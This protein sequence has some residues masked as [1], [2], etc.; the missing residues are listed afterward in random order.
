MHDWDGHKR[1]LTSFW[2]SVALRAG[3]YRG[4]PMSVHRA[5]PA[6]RS[7]HFERWLSLWRDTTRELLDEA[8]AARM[9]EYAERI[10]HGLRLGM[11]LPEPAQAR[12]DE[13]SLVGIVH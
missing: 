11:G 7:E 3:S 1:R 2:A 12:P 9:I 4:N 10:G 5:Q 13:I 6:I 8:A